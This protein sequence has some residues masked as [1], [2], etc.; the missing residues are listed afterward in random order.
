MQNHL[1]L[2]G[3][4]DT[5]EVCTSVIEHNVKYAVQVVVN[6]SFPKCA[7]DIIDYCSA[8][9]RHQYAIYH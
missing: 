9:D 1:F 6:F 7:Y 4:N 8:K 5:Q 3:E 2:Q